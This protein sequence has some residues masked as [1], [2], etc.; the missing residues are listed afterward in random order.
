MEPAGKSNVQVKNA[1]LPCSIVL[2]SYRKR[3]SLQVKSNVQVK[4]AILP[5]SI[6]LFSYLKWWSLH[7]S[8]KCDKHEKQ[9]TVYGCVQTAARL[10]SIYLSG[11][12]L[13]DYQQE[14]PSN[15][16]AYKVV[17]L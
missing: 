14:V 1:I 9:V 3:W 16:V 8:A 17:P 5:C 7:V 6:V 4:N 15:Q 2:F 11:Q 12:K 13:A 10:Q